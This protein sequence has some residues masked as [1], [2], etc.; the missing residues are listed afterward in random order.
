[1]K[2]IWRV[3]VLTAIPLAWACC[4]DDETASGDASGLHNQT[5]ETCAVADDCYDGVADGT[6]LGDVQCLD[7]VAGGYCTHLC[8]N[9]GD[10]CAVDGEC[11][12]GEKQV[13]GPFEST[14]MNMCFISCEK[15][16]VV[17]DPD[18]FCQG[19]H[20]DFICR[21]TGGGSTNR[22]VCVPGGS[23]PCDTVDDCAQGFTNCC[24]NTLGLFRCFDNSAA[25][26]LNCR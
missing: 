10:C 22:K 2:M 19:F 21:S 26:G 16:D 4:N 25:D 15:T 6:I 12:T 11:A 3:L 13:C 23:G 8:T 17:G 14:G 20:P 5:G 9:D 18:T 24:E 7:R 1:M